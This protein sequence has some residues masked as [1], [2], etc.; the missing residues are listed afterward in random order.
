[1]GPDQPSATLYWP[2]D[3]DFEKAGAR[4]GTL[5]R[6]QQGKKAPPQAPLD[7]PIGLPKHAANRGTLAHPPPSPPPTFLVP[8][9]G[10][11]QTTA[12]LDMVDG[13]HQGQIVEC[14]CSGTA[15]LLGNPVSCRLLRFAAMLDQQLVN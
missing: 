8:S 13:N 11:M 7:K 12:R 15:L 9:D 4:P 2:R 1:M 5:M 6:G 14:F 3:N 10:D